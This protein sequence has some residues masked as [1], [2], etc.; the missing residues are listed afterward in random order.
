MVDAGKA[1]V[2]NPGEHGFS[3][4]LYAVLVGEQQQRQRVRRA[5]RQHAVYNTALGICM[6]FARYWLAI[7]VLALAGALAA[8]SA[9][10]RRPARCRRTRRSSCSC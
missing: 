5:F 9:C 1:G 10:R 4:I 3:E 2:A 6:L 7:P 8:A